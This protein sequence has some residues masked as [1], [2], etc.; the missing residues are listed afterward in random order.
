MQ[1]ALRAATLAGI[2]VIGAAGPA[3]AQTE[4][5]LK[6]YFEGKMVRLRL[7]MPATQ[8]GIDIYPDA[9]RPLDLGAYS[10]RLKS[11]GVSFRDSCRHGEKRLVS[12]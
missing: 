2:F 1:I 12:Q 11:Y 3:L 10:N 7:D 6:S 8:E 9:Q 4:A 5:A